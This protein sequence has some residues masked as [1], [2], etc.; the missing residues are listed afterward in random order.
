MI[1][2]PA[3][4]L[5]D[6]QAVR[7]VQGDYGKKTVY[8]PDPVKVAR[9]FEEMGAKYLHVVD[10]DGAKDGNTAN[11]KTI[12]KIR[13]AI[14]I[15]M[16]LG[17][18][19]RNAE[20]VSMYLDDIGIN[21]V[22]LGTVA[23]SEPDFVKEMISKHGAEKIVVGVDV[24]SGT[25][26]TAGWLTDSRVDYLDFIEDLKSF[27]VKYLVVTDI[28][29]DGTLTSPNWEMYQKIKGINV[30]VS[31]GVAEEDHLRKAADYYGIIVGKAHYEGKVDLKKCLLKM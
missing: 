18:G 2:L 25:V 26:A 3:I 14:N 1:I 15:P 31:G 16:Q 11:L 13:E 29:R 6:G 8:N 27:G 5:Q 23:V 21:R 22:I 7:L 10:L 28:S 20:V 4:D 12:R 19:I 17:G 24:R 30:I 9:G